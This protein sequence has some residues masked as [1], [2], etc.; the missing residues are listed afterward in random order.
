MLAALVASVP[1]RQVRYELTAKLDGRQARDFYSF[2]WVHEVTGGGAR[3]LTQYP[4]PFPGTVDSAAV[5][6]AIGTILNRAQRGG[7]FAR[8]EVTLSDRFGRVVETMPAK[9]VR[10]RVTGQDRAVGAIGV[11]E[12]WSV[13]VEA[14]D[15]EQASQLAKA[16]RYELGREHVLATHTERIKP[17]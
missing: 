16:G 17:A 7:P 10:Y 12:A 4:T 1:P 5:F 13:V 8:G 11:F 15:A 14:E 9:P 6:G 2:D 3:R